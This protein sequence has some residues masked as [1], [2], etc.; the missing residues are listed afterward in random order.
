MKHF[1]AGLVWAA[2]LAGCGGGGD[3]RSGAAA[4]APSRAVAM[5]AAP[6]GDGAAVGAD[7][8]PGF[9]RANRLLDF[10]EANFRDWFPAPA[11][12]LWVPPFLVRYYPQTCAYLA[13]SVDGG[14]GLVLDGVYVVSGPFGPLPRYV[15]AQAAGEYR[16]EIQVRLCREPPCT[17]E[18][19]GFQARLPHVATLRAAKNLT[20]LAA[21]AGA[22]AHRSFRCDFL[23]PCKEVQ[24]MTPAQALGKWCSRRYIVV[25][26]TFRP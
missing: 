21:L 7:A 16:G 12:S 25:P 2:V 13:V 26:M 11:V 14:A 3:A 15:G 4:D 5:Q 24:C 18:Y 6:A 10:G 19:E 9:E 23:V 22:S 20:P 17:G 8:D 1:V